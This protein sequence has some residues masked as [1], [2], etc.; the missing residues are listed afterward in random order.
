VAALKRD[1]P[2]LREGLALL[3]RMET[4]LGDEA[5][6]A[7]S[8]AYTVQQ[9]HWPQ[10]LPLAPPEALHDAAR[11]LAEHLAGDRPWEGI[12]ELR[13]QAQAL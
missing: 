12:V 9:Y 4:D 5:L 10:L 6:D 8:V 2:A 7:L 1:L 13:G 3:R 11:A